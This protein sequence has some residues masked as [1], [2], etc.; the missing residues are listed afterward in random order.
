MG[1]P[2]F[3]S[4]VFASSEKKLHPAFLAYRC[5]VDGQKARTELSKG[6]ETKEGVTIWHTNS[7][8]F[9]SGGTRV[10]QVV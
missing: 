9:P 7:V 2:D 8:S 10:I 4:E 3:Q 5:Y 1:F 6:E